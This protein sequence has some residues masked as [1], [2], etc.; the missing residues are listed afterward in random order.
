M[1]S[2][3]IL[4]KIAFTLIIFGCNKTI[5]NRD[6]ENSTASKGNAQPFFIYDN[7][8]YYHKI[9][10]LNQS[11]TESYYNENV[12]TELDSLKFNVTVGRIPQRL[13]D[14][15]FIKDLDKIGYT[16][17]HIPVEKREELGIIFTKKNRPSEPKD[18]VK[19]IFYDIL[20][21]RKNNKIVGISKLSIKNLQTR[22]IGSKYNTDYFPTNAEH[23]KIEK[24][25]YH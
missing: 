7:I 4:V 25:L 10:E 5:E 3:S 16:K 15:T 17:I 22:V 21:F 19:P 2:Q 9:F 1:K 8:D 6:N 20:T 11:G 18:A 23:K 24:I 13:S 14:T 12:T